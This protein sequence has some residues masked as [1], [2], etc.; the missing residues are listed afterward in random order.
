MLVKVLSR[1][2]ICVVFFFP[3][4]YNVI[5][6]S[7]N[8]SRHL[9]FGDGLRHP[10]ECWAG[11]LEAFG[12]PKITLGAEECDEACFFFILF[13]GTDLGVPRETI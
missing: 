7:V 4:H 11:I 1:S 5:N 12:H 2:A 3:C 13:A 8:T 10:T 6:V 9:V